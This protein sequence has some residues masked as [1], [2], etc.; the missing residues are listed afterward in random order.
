M[1]CH[2]GAPSKAPL[3][4]DLAVKAQRPCLVVYRLPAVGDVEAE[5][6]E[7]G[8]AEGEHA[9]AAEASEHAP[10]TAEATVDA[11][12][13]WADALTQVGDGPAAGVDASAVD[14]ST[15]EQD[16]GVVVV[17]M[18]EVVAVAVVVDLV[19]RMRVAV[20]AGLVLLG[21]WASAHCE[22]EGSRLHSGVRMGH[23]YSGPAGMR[24]K[25]DGVPKGPR[26]G[27]EVGGIWVLWP[28]PR[29]LERL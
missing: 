4:L 15:Q 14:H 12:E 9:E 28:S 13:E 1:R 24:R 26:D 22:A 18:A 5:P 21:V 2:W 3:W 27:L 29:T 8:S 10:D 19:G 20:S 17:D 23:K 7:G 11:G 6:A 25:A 16:P